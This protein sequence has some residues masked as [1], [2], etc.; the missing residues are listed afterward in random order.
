SDGLENFRD[1]DDDGDT[2]PTIEEGESSDVDEDGLVDYLDADDDNDGIPTEVES[3]WTDDDV[4][5][6]GSPNWL[7]LD[8][9][10][11]GLLDE[12]EG[13]KDKDKDGVPDFVDPDG[14][15]SN[16]YRGSGGQCSHVTSS[17]VSGTWLLLMGLLGLRRRR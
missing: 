15:Y 4:D 5:G 6:D 14:I 16:Y 8:A 13:Q 10:G 1:P 11:D 9:D 2:V 12:Q 7:D 17:S 3:N